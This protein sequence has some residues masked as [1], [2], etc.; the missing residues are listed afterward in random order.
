MRQQNDAPSSV[1]SANSR[2]FVAAIAQSS[3]DTTRIIRIQ[4]LEAQVRDLKARLS[5]CPPCPSAADPVADECHAAII[6]GVTRRNEKTVLQIFNRHK[7][8]PEDSGFFYLATTMTESFKLCARL[9][10]QLFSKIRKKL[11]KS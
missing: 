5:L 11:V 6:N 2:T 7:L 4:D 8:K 9:M 3:K 10:L 1:P